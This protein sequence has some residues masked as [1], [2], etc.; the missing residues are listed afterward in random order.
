M[1]TTEIAAE[2]TAGEII[3]ALVSAGANQIN[4]E[5]ENGA[6]KGLRWIMRINGQDA[7]FAMPARIE[8]VYKIFKSRLRNTYLSDQ[9]KARLQ[10]KAR[11]V[12]WRQLL[13]WVQAQLA[14]IDCGMAEAAEVFFPY[15]QAAPNQTLF[16]VFK[17]RGL[18]MLPAPEERPQ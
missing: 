12:A 16:E 6:I 18:K 8:P 2:K 17:D 11:R 1:E 14:M 9:E 13:R 4:T 15:I 7:L 5:Y 3:S 10:E